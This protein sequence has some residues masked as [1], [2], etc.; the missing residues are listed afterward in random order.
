[1]TAEAETIQK[2]ADGAKAQASDYL[3]SQ[4]KL[5]DANVKKLAKEEIA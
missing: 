3:K 4:D 2:E 1:M 5:S